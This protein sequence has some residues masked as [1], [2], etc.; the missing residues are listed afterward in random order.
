MNC[1]AIAI[2]LGLQHGVPLEE[3]TDAFVFTRFEPNGMVS[4]NPQIKMATS[5]IDYIFRELAI[6]YLGRHDLAQAGQSDLQHDTIGKPR[7]ERFGPASSVTAPDVP[8]PA[9][10]AGVSAP[11]GSASGFQA[12]DTLAGETAAARSGDG[13]VRPVASLMTERDE[14]RLKGYEGDACWNCG[15]LTLVR[16]GTCLKCVTCGETS[17]C[18]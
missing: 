9:P 13:A 10:S 4:G 14:A 12:G 17:G 2:S 16:N 8:R 5:V 3:Y 7:T 6:S 11:A 1:F 18:S 15:Q